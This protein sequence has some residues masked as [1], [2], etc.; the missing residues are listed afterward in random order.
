MA[1]SVIIYLSTSGIY[2]HFN[3]GHPLHCQFQVRSGPFPGGWTLALSHRNSQLLVTDGFGSA[4]Y[5]PQARNALLVRIVVLRDSLIR[6][7]HISGHLSRESVPDGNTLTLLTDNTHTYRIPH[8]LA[9]PGLHP[10]SPSQVLRDV[11]NEEKEIWSRSK[12]HVAIDHQVKW[13]YPGRKGLRDPPGL[14]VYS[15]QLADF[16]HEIEKY[17]SQWEPSR[18]KSTMAQVAGAN[19]VINCEILWLSK[20]LLG[21]PSSVYPPTF[22]TLRPPLLPFH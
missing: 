13:L 9:A 10:S 16:I 6:L 8:P 2:N 3:L 1:N 14:A 5:S 12:A 22:Q 4:N 21:P 20:I 15:L 18:V 11:I 17:P 19:L 7:I